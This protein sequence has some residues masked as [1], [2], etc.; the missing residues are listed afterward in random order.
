MASESR[1]D[2]IVFG[3]TGYT[4]AYVVEHLIQ[5]IDKENPDLTWGVA[6]RSEKK[7]KEAL[8]QLSKYVE[9]N[10]DGVEVIVADVGDEDSILKMCQRGRIIINC[11]GPYSLYGEV[12]VKNCILVCA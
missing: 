5:T 6:G 3:A 7:T 1:L 8:K 2:I 10:L 9:K 12:V 11:V 4:G